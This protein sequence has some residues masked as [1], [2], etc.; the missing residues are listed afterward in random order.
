MFEPQIELF[1]CQA[2]YN[3]LN[4]GIE[5]A[6]ISDPYYLYL[7]GKF[8]LI[9]KFLNLWSF[10]SFELKD[11]RPRSDYNE[12]HIACAKNMRK[13]FLTRYFKYL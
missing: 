1:E 2:L 11:C 9:F 8:L 4:E 6:K 13:V 10:I 12:G 3:L 5:Y 7:I